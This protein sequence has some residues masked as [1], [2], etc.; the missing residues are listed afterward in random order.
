MRLWYFLIAMFSTAPCFAAPGDEF[1]DDRFDALAV[2]GEVWAISVMGSDAY[3]GGQFARA[4]NVE[5]S[6]IARWDGEKYWPLG[7]G[8]NG[9]GVRAIATVGN[10]LYVA[11][12]FTQA[13]GVEASRIAKWNGRTWLPLGSGVDGGVLALEV[14]DSELYIGGHFGSAGGIPATN[15]VRWNGSTWLPLG[16]GVRAIVRGIGGDFDDGQVT[17]LAIRQS[18]IFAGGRITKAGE[19]ASTNVAL[20][21]GV[22]WSELDGVGEFGRGVQALAWWGDSLYAG[23]LF[24]RAGLASAARIARWNGGA[25]AEIGGGLGDTDFAAVL[26]L[27]A[28]DHALFVGG[29]GYQKSGS[30]NLVK[31]TGTSWEALGSGVDPD[32]AVYALALQGNRLYVGGLFSTVGTRPARNFAIWHIPGRLQARQVGETA[33]ISW[34]V[35]NSNAVLEVSNSLT[36]RDWKVIDQTPTRLGGQ[37]KV[38]TSPGSSNHFYRLRIPQ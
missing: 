35:G 29:Q 14:A 12:F 17:A 25:W 16:N 11:G 26:S 21:D 22:K 36:S 27:A 33:E 18:H 6:N 3:V 31:W 34:A 4:G 32:G 1:W 8:V 23:G 24:T 28:R 2:E 10:D 20:W 9:S 5:A 30:T 15:I 13:G 37:L 19:V 7:T 38:T